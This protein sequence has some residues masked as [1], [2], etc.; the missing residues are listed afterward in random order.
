MIEV[1]LKEI[2]KIVLNYNDVLKKIED[3]NTAIIHNFTDLNNHWHD[4]RMINMNTS[5]NTE[6]QRILKLENNVKKQIKVYKTIEKGYEKIGRKVKCNLEAQELLN[7]KIDTVISELEDI[8]SDY[9]SLGSISFYPRA[10]MIYNQKREL[11]IAL[12][13]FKG[14]KKK[15]NN[16]FKQIKEIERSVNTALSELKVEVIIPNNYER[17]E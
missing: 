15:M 10:Y 6:K 9:D 14:I 17:N 13:S 1:N 16:K 4:Q 12:S 3:N 2:R 7:R 8:V 5:F 11:E